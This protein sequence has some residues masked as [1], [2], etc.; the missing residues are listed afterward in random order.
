MYSNFYN[1]FDDELVIHP[2]SQG[3]PTSVNEFLFFKPPGYE[4]TGLYDH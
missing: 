2:T 4:Q 3:V 1:R